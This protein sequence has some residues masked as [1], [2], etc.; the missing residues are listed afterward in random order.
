[1]KTRNYFLTL[2]FSLLA[3][4]VMSQGAWVV[5]A[6]SK[7]KKNP[8][9]ATP[10]SI[11]K[12]KALYNTHCKRCHGDPGKGNGLPLVPKT[13]DPASDVYQK[14]TDGEMFYKATTGRGAKP[15]F[16]DVLKEEER[17]HI[18]NFARSF[19]KK[20]VADAATEQDT[21]TPALAEAI[22]D[23]AQLPAGKLKIAL[24]F[25]E[26]AMRVYARAY[27][28][29]EGKRIGIA[30]VPVGIFVKRYFGDLSLNEE[31]LLTDAEGMV[32]AEFPADLPA[33]TAGNVEIVARVAED[34][35]LWGKAETSTIKTWGKPL[36]P[37]NIRDERSLWNST[38]K[39][40]L[41]LLISYFAAVARS[42]ERRVGKE[43]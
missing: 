1:M 16:K 5:P 43:C 37:Y 28:V 31:I 17:W 13:T 40:P 30:G 36:V 9:K 41:W 25:D 2:L 12:G 14:N 34:E 4:G 32:S 11:A 26:E 6:A 24:S 19:Q 42:E 15:S 38:W 27:K 7:G 8:V 29:N 23:T 3:L 20:K 35:A 33:D 39:A 10:E 21:L 18:I 22:V